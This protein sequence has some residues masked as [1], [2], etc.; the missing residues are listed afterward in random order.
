MSTATILILEIVI[1]VVLIV[2]TLYYIYTIR[3]NV[4]AIGKFLVLFSLG[5]ILYF[6]VAKPLMSQKEEKQSK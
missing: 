5:V 4:F 6:F 3:T 2:P 1:L